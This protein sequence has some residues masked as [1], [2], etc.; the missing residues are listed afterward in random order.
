M[1]KKKR[2]IICTFLLLIFAT[3]I[4]TVVSAVESYQYDMDQANGVDILEGFGAVLTLMIGGFVVL[5]ELDLLYTVYYFFIKP[6]TKA[7]SI[8]NVFS[9]VSLLLIYVY[10]ILS[11]HFMQLRALEIIPYVLFFVYI[12]LRIVYFSI[13]TRPLVQEK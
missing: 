1:K 8:L 11:S 12:I 10:T 2:I 5:Y 6:K 4:Y 9:N 13:A 3:A 7:K